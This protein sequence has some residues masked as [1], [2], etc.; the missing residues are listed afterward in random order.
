MLVA[1]EVAEPNTD[2][3]GIYFIRQLRFRF[4]M[5]K[6]KGAYSMTAFA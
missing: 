5:S 3:G 4:S 6:L 1:L 2:N